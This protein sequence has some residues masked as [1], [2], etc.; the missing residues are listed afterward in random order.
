MQLLLNFV[1]LLEFNLPSF[2]LDINVL[3][4]TLTSKTAWVSK[5]KQASMSLSPAKSKQTIASAVI[6][7]LDLVLA[8]SF[9][10]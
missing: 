4:L 7:V 8:A 3:V 10:K 1:K 6:R 2:V 5:V 9:F